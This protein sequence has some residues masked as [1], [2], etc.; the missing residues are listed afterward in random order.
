MANNARSRE[1]VLREAREQA[2]SSL[3][4]LAT[5]QM[6][7]ARLLIQNSVLNENKGTTFAETL[8]RTERKLIVNR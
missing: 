4:C 8:N 3:G 6:E 5:F 7:D 1:V 2:A